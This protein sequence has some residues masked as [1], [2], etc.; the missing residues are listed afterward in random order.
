[1]KPMKG[2]KTANLRIE[3]DRNGKSNIKNRR[4]V[5]DDIKRRP[6]EPIRGAFLK[7]EDKYFFSRVYV[8]SISRFDLFMQENENYILILLKSIYRSLKIPR[9]YTLLLLSHVA[10]EASGKKSS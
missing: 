1:M 6:A 9:F 10:A 2:R 8:K 7:G 3:E 5:R 4:A